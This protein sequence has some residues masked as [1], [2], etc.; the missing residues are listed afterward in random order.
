MKYIK[1]YEVMT[2]LP[3]CGTTLEADI[4]KLKSLLNNPE[5]VKVIEVKLGGYE[6]L[7]EVAITSIFGKNYEITA[8]DYP[9][10]PG[11]IIDE[12]PIDNCSEQGYSDGFMSTIEEVAKLL[13]DIDSAGGI[14]SYLDTEKYNL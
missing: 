11:L 14:D 2:E 10:E 4:E 6:N 9:Q 3:F 12:F 13:N 7:E 8:S 1:T 5:I